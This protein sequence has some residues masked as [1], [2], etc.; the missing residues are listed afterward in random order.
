MQSSDE[1][2]TGLAKSPTFDGGGRTF[3]GDL[4]LEN[5]R[6]LTL[7]NLTLDG[8]L[9][10]DQAHELRLERVRFVGQGVQVF[11][12]R[13]DG[14][15]ILDCEFRD[16][17]E[18]GVGAAASN[19]L[20]IVNSVFRGKSQ[21]KELVA[22]HPGIPAFFSDQ[23][24][25]EPDIRWKGLTTTASAIVGQIAEFRVV[26]AD[27]S[28]YLR[29]P[30]LSNRRG[31]TGRDLRKNRWLVNWGE[32]TVDVPC[33]EDRQK[34]GYSLLKLPSKLKRGTRVAWWT[35]AP[36]RYVRDVTL[37]GNKFYGAPSKLSGVSLYF[38]DGFRLSGNVA[39]GFGDY[40]LGVEFGRNG[41]VDGNTVLRSNPSGQIVLAGLMERVATAENNVPVILQTWGNP[42][43][44]IES[45]DEVKVWDWYPGHRPVYWIERV[46]VGGSLIRKPFGG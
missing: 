11:L 23:V 43:R 40:G 27:G 45:S 9:R 32:G 18:H 1:I 16:I 5:R 2:L 10:A 14:V 39:E 37:I 22:I 21:A 28:E 42:V 6:G 36:E 17:D 4:L 26:E 29:V 33:V 7:R 31:D 8:R 19:Q 46:S 24:R 3:R 20:R 38:V 25:R 13:S 35:D 41:R 12:V 44:D 30:T 34:E 15:T